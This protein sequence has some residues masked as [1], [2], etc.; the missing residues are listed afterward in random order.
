MGRWFRH[1]PA[2]PDTADGTE[3]QV[4]PHRAAQRLHDEMAHAYHEQREL[5]REISEE[6]LPVA[7]E[8]LRHE[9]E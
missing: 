2:E 3:E 6:F 5:D 8:S 4:A 9:V 7:V 1:R